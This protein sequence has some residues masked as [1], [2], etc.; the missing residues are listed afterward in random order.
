MTQIGRIEL[1]TTTGLGVKLG[2]PR[3]PASEQ[4]FAGRTSAMAPGRALVPTAPPPPRSGQAFIPILQPCAAFLAQLI[5]TALQAP[6]TR[7]RRR[8]E[9]A[10]ATAVYAKGAAGCAANSPSVSR[11]I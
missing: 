10:D 3:D 7:A 11:S 6:Q 2:H 4:E 8:A 5:A 1:P 9:P